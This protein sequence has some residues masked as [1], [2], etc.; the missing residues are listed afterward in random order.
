MLSLPLPSDLRVRGGA[1]KF[2][3]SPTSNDIGTM[4]VKNPYSQNPA[5]REFISYED[6]KQVTETH[7]NV[8]ELNELTKRKIDRL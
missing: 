6:G 8:R 1:P 2:I 3:K 5:A 7:Q 4:S